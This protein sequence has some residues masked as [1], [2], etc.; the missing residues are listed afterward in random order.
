MTYTGSV[1]PAAHPGPHGSSDLP[2]FAAGSSWFAP[3]PGPASAA[4]AYQVEWIFNI[5]QVTATY[6]TIMQVQTTGGVILWKFQ[7]R[8][9]AAR[10]QGYMRG[11]TLLVDPGLPLA[12]NGASQ[13]KWAQRKIQ[14]ARK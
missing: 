7:I 10:I 14:V 11:G 13:T 5:Q 3:V 2:S 12:S 6:R 9:D 8:N 4:G 1:E